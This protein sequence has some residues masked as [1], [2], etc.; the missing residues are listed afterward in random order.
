[1]PQTDPHCRKRFHPKIEQRLI[2]ARC[3]IRDSKHFDEFVI[4]HEHGKDP[5]ATSFI[6]S[7][8][9]TSAFFPYRLLGMRLST[10]DPMQKLVVKARLRCYNHGCARSSRHSHGRKAG[11]R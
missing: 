2:G 8:S 4:F 11:A 5:T 7:C 10:P 9:L 6:A 1:M 3:P